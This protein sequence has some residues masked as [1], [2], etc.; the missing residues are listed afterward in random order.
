M[1]ERC[2]T[3]LSVHERR[4]IAELR[5]KEWTVSAIA[6]QIGRCKSTVS[7]ELRRN[8]EIL[9]PNA[10]FVAPRI[11]PRDPQR[12]DELIR[13][14]PSDVSEIK[15]VWDWRTAQENAECRAR[16]AAQVR[17]RKLPE[18][19]KWV[20]ERLHDRWS[21]EQIAGRSKIDGPQSVSYEYVYT[22]VHREKKR[23]K[24]LHHLLKRFGRRKQR[25][26]PRQYNRTAA[27]ANRTSID[28]RPAI[29]E[30][31]SRLG[32]CEAD[33]IVGYRQSGYVLTVIDRKSRLVV[34]RRLE[35]KCMSEVCAQLQV[36]FAILGAVHT[37]T[38]D[39]GTEFNAH[40]ELTENTGVSVFFTHPYCST[41]RA[42]IEN[43]NGLVRYYLPKRSSFARIA[44]E[45]LDRIAAVLN[46]RP[47]KCL[48]YLTPAEVHLKQRPT[49]TTARVA[50]DS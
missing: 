21:P 47:R 13:T 39:N 20:I 11:Q 1:Q 15:R 2:F 17:R 45:R 41:E 29:V 31:R 3:H 23:G 12:L 10:S 43:A 34:L 37:V 24:K 5:S 27:Q 19:E 6:R 8:V 42:S 40:E 28:E 4:V 50:I 33:L 30:K 48:D 14:R 49:R 7:R 9:V 25:F 35:S 32:D 46:D 38:T 16:R 26:G 44:Q 22:L 36:A 18:T